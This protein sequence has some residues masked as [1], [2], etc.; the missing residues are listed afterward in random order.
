MWWIVFYFLLTLATY[1]NK[2]SDTWAII[3]IICSIALGL[4]LTPQKRIAM[5]KEKVNW[6]S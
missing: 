5:P 6:L 4:F 1:F 2:I 3:A